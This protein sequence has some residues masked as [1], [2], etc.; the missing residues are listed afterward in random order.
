VVDGVSWRIILDDLNTAYEQARHGQTVD[1]GD[2]TTSFQEWSTRLS[3]Y[4][5]D[6]ELDHELEHWAAAQGDWCA[7]PVDHDQP[8]PGTPAGT[9]QA[10]LDAEDT[11][12]LLRSAPTLYRTRI[13]DVLLAALASALSRWTGRD[14]VSLDLEGHGREDVIDGI[15]LSRTVG[16]FTT[17]HP[18]TLTVPEGNWRNV[19]KAIRR[20][21]RVIPGN[22]FGF[23][24]LRYLSARLPDEGHQPQV[25]F[26]YLG[27]WDGA[28]SSSDDGLYRAVHDS[29]GQD[30]DPAGRSAHLLEIV[31]GVA[32]DEL[33]FTVYYQPDRH[34]RSTVEDFAAAF[35]DALRGIAQDC[36]ESM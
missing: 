36:R 11:A 25:V 6:G 22:G 4:V 27:Q 30:S 10:G 19:V 16:W 33:G 7:L 18:V 5:A 34:N 29:I 8:R 24:A 13:N 9:V 2:K 3:R 35:A 31:G 26:N 20:Q 21:L 17:I 15:D 14:T 23:G 32:G 1:L 28:A 12:A